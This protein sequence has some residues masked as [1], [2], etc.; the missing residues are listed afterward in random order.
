M[1]VWVRFPELPIEFYDA[2]VLIQIGSAIGHVLRIDSFTSSGIRGS[3]ARLCIQ[4]NLDKPLIN[5]M[6]VGRLKQKVMYERKSSLCFYCGRLGHKHESCCYRI[7]PKVKDA[8]SEQA[9]TNPLRKTKWRML[10]G[11]TSH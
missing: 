6:E 7:Q 2:T 3:Y 10:K 5:T 9:I 4:V 11:T 8:E 1:A